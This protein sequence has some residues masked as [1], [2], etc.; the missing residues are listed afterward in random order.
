[1]YHIGGRISLIFIRFELILLI[2]F[3]F[4]LSTALD[5]IRSFIRRHYQLSQVL[6]HSYY[7]KLVPIHPGKEN[8][9]RKLSLWKYLEVAV[10]TIKQ[11]TSKAYELHESARE[12]IFYN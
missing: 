11:S 1:M 2:E 9:E 7:P 3:T 10:H 12:L 8:S 4:L 6:V 5:K